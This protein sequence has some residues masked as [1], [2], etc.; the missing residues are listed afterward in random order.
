MD[1][2]S[3]TPPTSTHS[4]RPTQP[5]SS[6]NPT[7]NRIKMM[8]KLS[9]VKK[10]PSK[11][12]TT[13]TQHEDVPVIP[14][15]LE[16]MHAQNSHFRTLTS[17]SL[18]EPLTFQSTHPATSS[19]TGHR[20]GV[21][22]N[23]VD[24]AD[25]EEW[26]SGLFTEM[27]V[28]NFTNGSD[29]APTSPDEIAHSSRN[30]TTCNGT[31]EMGVSSDF[32]QSFRKRPRSCSP[33]ESEQ[34]LLSA[35]A[36]KKHKS[37]R[38]SSKR[39]KHQLQDSHLSDYIV[40]IPLGAVCL[41]HCSNICE[42][43]A[44]KPGNFHVETDLKVDV[45]KVNRNVGPTSGPDELVVSFRRTE[46]IRVPTACVEREENFKQDM[47]PLGRTKNHHQSCDPSCQSHD[48]TQRP[49]FGGLQDRFV[50][51]NEDVAF[52]NSRG[53][54]TEG[55]DST[56]SWQRPV[57]EG[58]CPGVDGCVGSDGYWYE[59]T[60][61]IGSQGEEVTVLPYVYLER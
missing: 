14:T 4:T 19:Q 54:E 29:W 37:H 55:N 22:S 51:Q 40:K 60:E 5:V 45:N 6:I 53:V 61:H 27:A 13:T 25:E 26:T 36:H 58:V 1:P 47:L 3:P 16:G 34:H 11:S 9:S 2:P 8:Q 48:H 18:A 38:H 12:H 41:N 35:P 59:W 32:N 24:V 42:G 31:V 43:L 20:V 46:L 50:Q 52:N 28:M 15:Q 30:V 57:P 21:A 17:H 10:S 49:H 7:R 33:S 44:G 39:S 23:A 56:A